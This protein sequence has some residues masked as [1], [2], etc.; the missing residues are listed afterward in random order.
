MQDINIYPLNIRSPRDLAAAMRRIG[1]DPRSTAYFQPKRLTRHIFVERVDFRAA[2]YIKQELLAR[3]GD[4]VVSRHV[5]D[6]GAD[7][8]DVLL[9][10]TD[11]ELDALLKKMEAMNCWGLEALRNGLRSALSNAA[12]ATWVLSLP[13]GRELLL[14]A[15]TKIMGVLN[16]TEDSFHAP[17]RVGLDD[18]LERA[19]AMLAD[20]ADILDVGAESTRPGSTPLSEEEEQGRLIPAIKE[21]RNAFP[22]AVISADT[23]KGKVALAAAEA[24]ADIINDVGGFALS[25][26]MLECAAHSGL[27][28][29][30]SHVKGTPRD[31]QASP[32]Y[33]NLL[34]ELN[35]Y[36]Q[37][38]INEAERAGLS[39]ERIII[40]PGIGFGKRTEDN[41][42]ILKEL[43]SLSVFGRPILLGYSRKKFIG[44]VTDAAGT[45]DRL[46]GTT[47]ISALVEGRAQ[48]VRVHDVRENKSALS[49]ARAIKAQ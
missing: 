38:K 34:G 13:K 17:S 20:G 35:V 46:A 44:M 26:D 18:V 45:D 21:L 12:V 41:L 7:A 40:D 24:G 36:F 25:S 48:A 43:E 16:L 11:G 33:E 37:M 22:D 28:Y 30:L 32:A 19:G 1:A 6:A 39:R 23:Y 49:M 29:L 2:A 8:S 42:L 15:S 27:P 4:A 3:G 31:M 10:G 5:I 9:M 14:D 47:A